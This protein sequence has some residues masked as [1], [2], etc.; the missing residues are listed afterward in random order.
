MIIVNL[1]NRI[2]AL[3][4]GLALLAGGAYL[5]YTE[6]MANEE[7]FADWEKMLAMPFIPEDKPATEENGGEE[8]TTPE[9]GESEEPT[10]PEDGGGDEPTAPEEGGGDEPTAPEEGGG[11]EPTAPEEGGGD[12][13]TSPADNI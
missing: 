5:T 8:S 4:I 6:T 7:M 2:L 1:I 9:D 13:P 10:T 3:V 11:D 12:E